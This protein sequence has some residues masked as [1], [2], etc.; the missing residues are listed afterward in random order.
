M[1]N[2]AK[3]SKQAVQYEHDRQFEKALAQYA[4]LFDEAAGAD[5]EVDVAMYNRAGDV[6]M[7]VGDGA[8]AVQYYERAIDGYA[9]GGLLNNAIAVCNKVLRHAPDNASTHY[10]LAVL[11]AKQGFK[12]DA[13][14]HFVEYAERMH[15]A[16]KQDEALR[17]LTEFAA[18]CPP[19]DDA[20]TLLAQHLSR[21]NRGADVST[22]LQAMLGDHAGAPAAASPR[23]GS[24]AA[25][26]VPFES[27][28]NLVFLDISADAQAA[29][30]LPDADVLGLE[31]TSLLE[32]PV[33]DEASLPPDVADFG[34]VMELGA[35]ELEIEDAP[36]ALD[37][38]V[39]PSGVRHEDMALD[40]VYLADAPIGD[41]RP[42]DAMP[43][44]LVDDMADD[45]GATFDVVA[46]AASRAPRWADGLPGELPVLSLGGWLGSASAVLVGAPLADD[47]MGADAFG[48]EI[49][50]LDDAPSGE[51]VFLDADDAAFD[52]V[53]VHEAASDP[54]AAHDAMADV[55]DA[56]P[57]KTPARSDAGFLDLGAWLR[58]D[59]PSPSTRLLTDEST[60]TGDETA[61][62]ER[63]LGIFRAGL[64]RNLD[65]ADFDSH[66][67]LGVAF[68]EMG[69]IDEAISEF[70][71]AAQSPSAA[72]RA[73]EALGQCFLDRGSPELAVVTLERAVA[74][75]TDGNREE[76]RLLGVLYLLGEAH[77]RLGR[78]APARACFE[79]VIANDIEFRDAASRLTLLSAQSP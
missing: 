45:D 66:Y 57:A 42:T 51:M 2:L 35:I 40:P 30:A 48:D 23:S 33:D 55:V 4:R 41:V 25:G 21:G 31:H 54:E 7:R 15:R 11:H 37:F 61:D 5:E 1:S 79:R 12:G 27:A 18:L 22:R 78:T 19:G 20:R 53:A 49:P 63:L 34:D 76:S 67:D 74:D 68:R 50:L 36:V 62:F 3:L 28:A 47:R 32:A 75:S 52:D 24:G 13:K 72:L 77:V 38:L 9:A 29:P 60:P 43:L 26:A 6:A 71:K 70:Q 44:D 69:L 14:H 17:A 64:A 56:V 65:P 46:A 58:D 39:E 59:E 10:T 16:G 8:R 73:H